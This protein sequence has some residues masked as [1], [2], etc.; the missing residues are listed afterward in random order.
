MIAENYDFIFEKSSKLYTTSQNILSVY[1][2]MCDRKVLK[3][4]VIFKYFCNKQTGIEEGDAFISGHAQLFS[5]I[6]YFMILFFA[7]CHFE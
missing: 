7:S 3:N 4:I 1:K 6:N 5:N 2:T